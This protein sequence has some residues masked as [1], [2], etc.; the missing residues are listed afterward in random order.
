MLAPRGALIGASLALTTC[1][2]TGC[3]VSPVTVSKVLAA[4]RGES[5]SFSFVRDS[6]SDYIDQALSIEN[7]GDDALAPVLKV[8]ALDE[9]GNPLPDVK[10][11]T[12]FGSDTGRLVVL[13]GHNWDALEF[14]GPGSDEVA[15]VRVSVVR[16]EPVDYPQVDR[17]PEAVVLEDDGTEGNSSGRFASVSVTNGND[18][19]IQVRLA[20]LVWEEPRTGSP[21]QFVLSQPIGD[22]IT[23]PANGTADTPVDYAALGTMYQYAD[24]APASVLPYFSH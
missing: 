13:P 3:A 2:L 23:V 19:P 12:A 14:L 15:D 18:E 21:Q 4:Q 20:Y 1:L 7:D 17:D 24:R 6:G 16:A 5:L 22:L 8:V 9:A 10:V 11:F